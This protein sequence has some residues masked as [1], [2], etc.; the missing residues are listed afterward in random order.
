MTLQAKTRPSKVLILV[1]CVILVGLAPP[2]FSQHAR[3]E[4]IARLEALPLVLHGNDGLLQQLVIV[5]TEGRS[6]G[7][8]RL[9]VRIGDATTEVELNRAKNA[10]PSQALIRIPYAPR[11]RSAEFVLQSGRRVADRKVLS[12]NPVPDFTFGLFAASHVCIAYENTMALTH[13]DASFAVGEAVRLLEKYP[14]A[15][16]SIEFTWALKLYWDEH[17]ERQA[18]IKKLL[19]EGRLEVGGRFAPNH[20]DGFDGESLARQIAAAQWWLENMVGSRTH[21]TFDWDNPVY[22]A[23]EPQLYKQAGFDGW[24]AGCYYDC[25]EDRTRP[26]TAFRDGSPFFK[27]VGVDGSAATVL[28]PARGLQDVY[29]VSQVVGLSTFQ[30]GGGLLRTLDPETMSVSYARSLAALITGTQAR[31]GLNFLAGSADM[32]DQTYPHE[33]LFQ[34][35]RY[36]NSVF[37]TPRIQFLPATSLLRRAN[38]SEKISDELVGDVPWWIRQAGNMLVLRYRANEISASLRFAE[39]M[40]SLDTLQLGSLYPAEA[41]AAGWNELLQVEQH[42]QYFSAWGN[43]DDIL[44]W[45][46]AKLDRAEAIA[47]SVAQAGMHELASRVQSS[48]SGAH[49]VVFNRLN[50]ESNDVVKVEVPG[51]QEDLAVVDESGQTVP[52]NSAP[53]AGGRQ[54]SFAAKAPPLGYASYYLQPAAAKNPLPST[55]STTIENEFYRLTVDP[56]NG[57]ITSLYDKSLQRE[58]VDP[59]RPSGGFRLLWDDGGAGTKTWSISRPNGKQW[60]QGDFANSNV[61]LQRTGAGQELHIRGPLL[62]QRNPHFGDWREVQYRLTPGISRLDIK[63]TYDWAGDKSNRAWLIFELAL[64]LHQA[65]T[66]YGSPFAALDYREYPGDQPS[67]SHLRT[68]HNWADVYD[69]VARFGISIAGPST[70][71][72][73]QPEGIGVTL[74]S[75]HGSETAE[76]CV[77]LDGRHEFRYALRSHAGDWR[78]GAAMQFGYEHEGGGS[79]LQ[80]VLATTR[81]GNL[82]PSQTLLSIQGD[83]IA[84]TALKMAERG[85]DLVLRL[86]PTTDTSATAALPDASREGIVQ[87]WRSNILED[88]LESIP[89]AALDRLPL[90]KWEIVSLRLT[91]AD[92]GGPSPAWK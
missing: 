74:I 67:L 32:G 51:E 43:G 71:I 11:P 17:P 88:A 19:Q 68:M 30:K 83:H 23:Q 16:W 75:R 42:E 60:W 39:T 50:W 22:Y 54:I 63:I 45:S 85:Q 84:V 91:L 9:V 87:A 24:V 29:T 46:Q 64:A 66:T 33:D 72:V 13:Q 73:I 76:E 79:P 90:K 12:L 77:G 34:K 38:T 62:D 58:L 10:S 80:A 59:A 28:S 44:D 25:D 2:A 40:A 21:V 69:P 92:R 4:A 47:H 52:S 70:Q 6:S 57:L 86:H 89:L 48:R 3:A 81:G 37:A 56:A 41:L 14:E 78:E 82:R 1:T 7:T 5:E 53:E 18:L 49:V 20:Q 55:S 27:H 15:V 31:S 61:V 36:W 65:K 35:A 26:Q 8:E